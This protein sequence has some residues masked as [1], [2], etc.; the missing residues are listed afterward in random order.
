VMFA[1]TSAGFGGGAGAGRLGVSGA[2]VC[3][4]ALSGPPVVTLVV[5]LAHRAALEYW[6]IP[7]D[8]NDAA[9][10]GRTSDRR[11]YFLEAPAAHAD[12]DMG[13]IPASH[14]APQEDG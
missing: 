6:R 12:E 1:C 4:R 9:R 10:D 5:L 7:R 11:D 3:P 13:D 2:E 8:A 14:R